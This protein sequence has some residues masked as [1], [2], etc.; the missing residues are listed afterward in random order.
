MAL[1]LSSGI[2]RY[3]HRVGVYGNSPLRAHSGENLALRNLGFLGGNRC[4]DMGA[5]SFS[6]TPT[7]ELHGNLGLIGR[8]DI[9]T[10][11]ISGHIADSWSADCVVL[12]LFYPAPVH[13]LPASASDAPR[14][15]ATA[16]RG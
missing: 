15:G 1:C 14:C 9:R 10:S 13:H 2:G 7:A 4:V 11:G 3:A 16:E 8:A 5:V 12:G 6:L